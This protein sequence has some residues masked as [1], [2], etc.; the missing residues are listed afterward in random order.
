[1]PF[2]E[3]VGRLDAGL[4]FTGNFSLLRY[5][6]SHRPLLFEFMRAILLLFSL[7]FALPGASFAS[8][9]LLVP[10]EATVLA[11]Y[12]KFVAGRDI[13]E[14]T[15]Y[16]GPG[17]RRDVIAMILVQQALRL[18]GANLQFKFVATG[19]SARSPRLLTRGELLLTFDSVW[20][21]ATRQYAADILI[22]EAVI[23]RG[24]YFAAIATAPDNQ[25]VQN[26]RSAADIL[27]YPAITRWLAALSPHCSA[28]CA[29]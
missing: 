14:I 7:Y 11:D 9:P 10:I 27:P 6:A 24:E 15:Y 1:M 8:A 29:T 2:H 28:G 5:T 23:K 16:G 19:S 22:S 21:Q 20:R 3:I 18:G 13:S 12:Q 4:F 17:A 26:A 25:K